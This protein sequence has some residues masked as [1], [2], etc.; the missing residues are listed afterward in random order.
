MEQQS[1]YQIFGSETSTDLDVCFFVDHLGSIEENKQALKVFNRQII[2]AGKPVNSNLAII[3]N[4][5]VSHCFKGSIDELNNALFYTYHLH[6]QAHPLMIKQVVKRDI[7]KKIERCLR[8]IVARFSRTAIRQQ[9]KAALKQGIR[10]KATL[11]TQTD[12]ATFQGFGRNGPKT[13]VLKTIAFQCGQTMGLFDNKEL[14]TKTTI[15]LTYPALEPYLQRQDHHS[16]DLQ[17]FMNT[18]MF[19]ILNRSQP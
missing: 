18:L 5:I 3:N 10:E 4:G 19:K 15:A 16:E 14:Y 1:K 9:V 8:A 12:M 13:E 6:R 7:D 11:L 2:N 17:H